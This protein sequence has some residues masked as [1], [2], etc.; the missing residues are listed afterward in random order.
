VR[1]F[2]IGVPVAEVGE[3]PRM[4]EPFE[5]P[6]APR[7]RHPDPADIA[8]ADRTWDEEKGNDADSK[9]GDDERRAT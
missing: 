1:L 7:A 9:E 6:A 8:I 5:L 3:A 4:L 2:D